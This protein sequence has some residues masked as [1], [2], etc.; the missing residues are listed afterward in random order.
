MDLAPG[1]KRSL[2]SHCVGEDCLLLCGTVRLDGEPLRRLSA[3]ELGCRRAVLEQAPAIAAG[4]SVTELVGFGVPRSVSPRQAQA[5]V[6][7][8][9]SAV[10]L[11]Q[12]RHW[13]MERLSGGEQ[14]RVHL[15]RVLAQLRAGQVMG[16][17]RWLL[18]DEPTA[19]LDPS[20]Q[21]TVIRLARQVAAEGAGVVIVVHD[22]SVA[23]A[24]ASRVVLMQRGQVVAWGP[25]Q[26]V[27]QPAIL[28][29]VYGIPFLR[30]QPVPGR[31]IVA[32]LF[33][34]V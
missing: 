5:I 23:V 24:V 15:A 8:A 31:T 1:D 33:P 2:L 29:S 27:L 19:H 17:G 14:Q 26:D 6:G 32:P 30:S 22:L 25:V 9:V 12:K 28:E 10:E 34:L 11:T 4:F 16:R 7:Q 3:A 18:L 20:H 21:A 13:T